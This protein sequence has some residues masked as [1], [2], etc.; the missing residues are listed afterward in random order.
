MNTISKDNIMAT[1]NLVINFPHVYDKVLFEELKPGEL[2]MLSHRDDIVYMK[3]HSIVSTDN[4][5][6]NAVGLGCGNHYDIY[7]NNEVIRIKGILDLEY[8]G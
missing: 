6:Y 1:N 3:T 5:C 2:F 8:T 7:K 4:I